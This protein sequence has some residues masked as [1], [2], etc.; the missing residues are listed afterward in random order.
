M[1]SE[2][3]FCFDMDGNQKWRADLGVMDVGLVDDPGYQ[4]GPA[5]SPVILG[6]RVIVQN[7]RHKDAFLAAYASPMAGDLAHHSRRVPVV[8]HAALVRMSARTEIETN[9]GKHI[10]GSIRRPAASCGGSRTRTHR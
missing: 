9:A 2:G 3:L 10:R 5:S 7:D 8:G 4:W 1:G 6:D